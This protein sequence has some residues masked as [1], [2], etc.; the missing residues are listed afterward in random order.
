MLPISPESHMIKRGS[1][2]AFWRRGR[3]EELCRN[4]GRAGGESLGSAT[5]DITLVPLLP[6]F[7]RIFCTV[8]PP[9]HLF[10]APHMPFFSLF[11]S[12]VG[13]TLSSKPHQKPLPAATQLSNTWCLP[14]K[15][16]NPKNDVP[17][18]VKCWYVLLC[19][20][21][22]KMGSGWLRF[23]WITPCSFESGY[24][25]GQSSKRCVARLIC[26]QSGDSF[27]RKFSLNEI[28]P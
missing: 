5:A 3:R 25:C 13:F 16:S 14:K 22:T 28:P 20:L 2:Q 9:F 12:K 8:H 7:I 18:K 19:P 26:E 1:L 23:A 6:P 10:T 15:C 27:G 17:S 21:R 4:A 24:Q 11:E